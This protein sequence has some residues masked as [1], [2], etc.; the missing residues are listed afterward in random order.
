MYTSKNEGICLKVCIDRV[1]LNSGSRRR[2][3]ILRNSHFLSMVEGPGED[4]MLKLWA[5]ECTR[6]FHDRLISDEDRAQ[7]VELTKA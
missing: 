5:H 6:T 2:T 1:L 3:F 7:F 4:D